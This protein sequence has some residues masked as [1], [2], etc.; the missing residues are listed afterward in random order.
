M[1]MSSSS[2]NYQLV[3]IMIDMFLYK[4]WKVTFVF[5]FDHNRIFSDENAREEFYI[6][7]ELFKE[8]DYIQWVTRIAH[9]ILKSGIISKKG[10]TDKSFNEVCIDC[11]NAKITLNIF[12]NIV[13]DLD[14]TYDYSR[15][16]HDGVEI[17]KSQKIELLDLIRS[18]Y[19][20]G[21]KIYKLTVQPDLPI[22]EIFSELINSLNSY[23]SKV[24]NADKLFTLLHSK[25]ELFKNNFSK[26]YKKMVQYE[27]PLELFTSFLQ[28]VIEDKDIQDA[29]LLLQCRT[30]IQELNKSLSMMPQAKQDK[31][32]TKVKSLM[33]FITGYIDSYQDLGN[34]QQPEDVDSVIE[35]YEKKFLA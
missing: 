26:Y 14:I 29:T 30:L 8:S 19:T 20:Q 27:S 31:N 21:K 34:K 17:H 33:D 1:S 32:F 15:A 35:Q 28:D 25:S 2:Y 4:R 3:S 18:I 7:Y 9:R 23:K 11:Q 12:T 6:L 16:F 5:S 24:R 13:N 22:D 10:A